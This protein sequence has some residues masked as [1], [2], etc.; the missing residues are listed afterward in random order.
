MLMMTLFA[1]PGKVSN[2]RVTAIGS[3][4]LSVAWDPRDDVTLYEIRH[5]ELH[6]VTRISVN[7][8]SSSNFTLLRL[9]DDTQYS[10][11]VIIVVVVF[12][13]ANITL[14]KLH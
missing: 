12:F 1:V 7:V 4:T 13:Y 14:M 11:Q 5:W 2:V 9:S 6:D 3:D 8:T 10:F